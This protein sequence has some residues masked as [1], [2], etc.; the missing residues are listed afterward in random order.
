MSFHPPRLVGSDPELGPVRHCRTCDEWLPDD[1]EFW[2]TT[3]RGYLM[4]RACMADLQAARYQRHKAKRA[5]GLCV[6]GVCPVITPR[7]KCY[8]HA[9]RVAA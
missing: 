3:S 6:V 9:R 1:S 7:R 2:L 5:I 8:Y 4:C